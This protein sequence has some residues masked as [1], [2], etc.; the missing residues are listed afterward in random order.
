[1]HTRDI[2]A[3]LSILDS[4]N[5]AHWTIDG[6]PRVDAL[7]DLGLQALTREIVTCA[8]PL[9]SR[10][11]RELPDLEGMR[12]AADKLS[13]EADKAER[14]A[15]EAKE[16][17]RQAQAKAAEADKPIKD[18]HQLTRDNQAWIESQNEVQ[19][20]RHAR[21]KVIDDLVK[22]AG[23]P[24]MFGK[25]PVEVNEAARIKAKR[26]AGLVLPA[27]AAEK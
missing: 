4:D 3:A 10:T 5:D 20:Q 7:A 22:S 23:G 15:K 9:F 1:M 19:R 24:K 26:R 2:H 18:T 8:A 16:V 25:H 6:A 17:A 21:G 14:A 11:N 12:A 13:E 27:K